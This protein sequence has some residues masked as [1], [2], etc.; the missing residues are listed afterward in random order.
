MKKTIMLLFFGI[1]IAGI[2]LVIGTSANAQNDYSGFVGSSFKK[3]IDQLT[4][5]VITQKVESL[6]TEKTSLEKE[7]DALIK[8]MAQLDRINSEFKGI[9]DSDEASL[10][11]KENE[12]LRHKIVELQ[13]N[14]FKEN[15]KLYQELGTA[16]VQAKVFDHAIDAYKKSLEIDPYNAEVHYNLGLL[17]KHYQNNSKKATYHFRQYLKLSPDAKNRKD[18]EFL[19]QMLN[20]KN[21]A[22]Y[23]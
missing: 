11:R 7:K 6:K 14:Q 21:K 8:E 19:I 20:K 2:F 18:V 12:E 9:G 16:Y 1:L 22:K 5:E 17:Y 3:D 15:A 4:A 23:E 13:E 10:L